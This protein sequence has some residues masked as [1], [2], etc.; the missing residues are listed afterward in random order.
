MEN[1]KLL[2]FRNKRQDDRLM[3]ILPFIAFNSN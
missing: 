1:E 3:I 2:I